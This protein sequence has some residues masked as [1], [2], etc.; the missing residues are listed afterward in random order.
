M[1]LNKENSI[2]LVA[3]MASFVVAYV[4]IV[5][6]VALPSMAQS[7][8]L[9]NI[10]QNWVINAFLFSVAIFA[11]PT[12]NLS[13]KYGIKRSFEIGSLILLIGVLAIPFATSPIFLILFRAI[14]GFGAAIIYNTVMNIL[15]MGVSK[16]K[17]GR[18]IGI[19]IAGVNIGIGLAPVLGGVLTYE[20]GWQS[21]FLFAV[22]FAILHILIS[23]FM[24]K[25]EWVIGKENKFDR[26]GAI[27]WAVAIF[28]FVYGFTIIKQFEGIIMLIAGIALLIVFAFLELKTNHP[29]YDVGVFKNKIFASSSFAAVLSFIATYFFTYILNYHVQYIMGFNSEMAGM[30]LFVTPFVQ[31]LVSPSAGRLSDKFNSQILEAIGMSLV[32]ISL[33]VLVFLNETT[34]LFVIVTAMV[35]EGVGYAIFSAP[36]TNLIMSSLKEEKSTVASVS[37]TVSRVLGQTLSLAMLTT[38]FNF[39]M[40]DVAIV[41]KYYHLLTLSS[42]ITCIVGTVLGIVTILAC[43]IGLA[44]LKRKAGA[45]NFH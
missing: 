38:I 14:Q 34:P 41:P 6:T 11:V 30:L 33:L 8:G 28:L 19:L 3:A 43:L 37:V 15:T 16:E 40:G 25:D 17:R 26:K 42:N 32:T 4:S 39:I 18:A 45:N 44:P 10:M 12:G 2:I 22:P 36:N 13:G 9:S 5:P 35:L 21:I 1:D 7:F 29:V 24:I 27:L 20:F 23:H 31:I